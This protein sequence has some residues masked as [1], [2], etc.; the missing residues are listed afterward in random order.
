MLTRGAESRA[1]DAVSVDEE[2]KNPLVLEVLGR[3]D[4]CSESDLEEA[5]VRHL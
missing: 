3:K 5:Q 2:V 1:D 4:E